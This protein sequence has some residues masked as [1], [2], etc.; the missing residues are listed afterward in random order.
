ML[1]DGGGLGFAEADEVDDI[2]ED[3]DEAV[4]GRAEEVGEGEVGNAALKRIYISICSSILELG[5]IFEGSRSQH[6]PLRGVS[7]AR[8]RSPSG[9]ECRLG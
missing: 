7:V 5:S 2:G 9:C 4:V 1:V 6:L 3:F 8:R